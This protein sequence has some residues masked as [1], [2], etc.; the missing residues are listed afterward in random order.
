MNYLNKYFYVATLLSTLAACGGGGGSGG[1][2]SSGIQENSNSSNQEQARISGYVNNVYHGYSGDIRYTAAG[3]GGRNLNVVSKVSDDSYWEISSLTPKLGTYSCSAGS[4]KV[5]LQRGNESPLRSESCKLT[6]TE[7]NDRSVNGYFS[8][9]LLGVGG[10]AQTLTNGKFNIVLAEAIL[11]LDN[12][13]LSDADDNC[14]FDVNQDQA[15]QNG[16]NIGD[17]CEVD[18]SEQA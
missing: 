4:L 2:E 14:P 17:A 10:Q 12:D 18:G 13:G 7:A 9:T 16:N 1:G 6:V 5:T 3:A 15:D 11:D 8:A